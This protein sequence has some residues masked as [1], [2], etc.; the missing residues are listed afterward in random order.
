MMVRIHRPA[1]ARSGTVGPYASMPQPKRK[2]AKIDI[3]RPPPTMMPKPVPVGLRPH[4]VGDDGED[5]QARAREER[6]RGPVRLDAPAE[7]EGREDR[8]PA[9]A[10]DHDAEARAGGSQ[11]PWRRR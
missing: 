10:A 1:L 2:G 3:L 9:A 5:P 4:G 7:E 8:H 6:H 11:A